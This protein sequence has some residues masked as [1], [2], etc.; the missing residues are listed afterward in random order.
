MHGV[1]FAHEALQA[2]QALPLVYARRHH[3]LYPQELPWVLLTTRQMP[4]LGHPSRLLSVC[5]VVPWLARFALLVATALDADTGAPLPCMG[6]CRSV[7]QVVRAARH[8]EYSEDDAVRVVYACRRS[9]CKYF[10]SSLLVLYSIAGVPNWTVQK[11]QPCVHVHVGICSPIHMIDL[12][13]RCRP[14]RPN[15]K[16]EL[17]VLDV[18]PQN[19]L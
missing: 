6:R 3:P 17:I 13:E 10:A 2:V 19:S 1:P 5:Q 16:H 15:C 14:F 9:A 8:G 4:R 11:L 12:E 7:A 18:H